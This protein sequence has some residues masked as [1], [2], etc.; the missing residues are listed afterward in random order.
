MIKIQA[1]AQFQLDNLP[2]HAVS[3]LVLHLWKFAAFVYNKIYR[4]TYTSNYVTY[5]FNVKNS[6]ISNNPI[7]HKYSVYM[8]KQYYLKQFSLA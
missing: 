6:S 8:S 4:L 7:Y 5:S 2:H 1:L 3:S